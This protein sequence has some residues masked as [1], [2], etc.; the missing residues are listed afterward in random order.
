MNLG[1]KIVVVAM[2]FHSAGPEQSFKIVPL[3]MTLVCTII[4]DC[5]ILKIIIYVV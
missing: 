2:T 5:T 4:E 3:E 1:L